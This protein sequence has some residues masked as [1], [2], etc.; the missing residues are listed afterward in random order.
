MKSI[1]EILNDFQRD[2]EENQMLGEGLLEI[3]V[4]KR[5]FD[6]LKMELV[7]PYNKVTRGGYEVFAGNPA[8][9]GEFEKWDEAEIHL[10]CRSLLVR[11]V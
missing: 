2:L 3:K 10:Q 7:T 11:Q 6:R 5:F 8:Q 1:I 9:V 4:D